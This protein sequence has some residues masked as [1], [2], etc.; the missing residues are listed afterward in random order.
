MMGKEKIK[1]G[2]KQMNKMMQYL[3]LC[4]LLLLALLW[5]YPY[6][7]VTIASVKNETDI[8]GSGLLPSKPMTLGHYKFILSTAAEIGRTPFGRAFFNS[9][10]ISSTVTVFVILIGGLAGYSLAKHEFPGR[11][12]LTNFIIFQM[13][14]PT[15]LF[16]VPVFLVIKNLHMIDTYQGMILPF[17]ASAWAVF[18]FYQFFKGIPNDLIESVRIDGGRELLIIFRIMF[19]LSKPIITIIGMF[20]FMQRWDEYLWYIV[21]NKK[22]AFMPMTNLLAGYMKSYGENLG[23]QMAGVIF[24]TFP[25]IVLFIIFRKSFTR[26]ITMTGLKG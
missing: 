26:G 21:L 6:I 19:P 10:F 23:A 7:W 18:L 25:I 8:T 17:V 5:L 20:I 22:N 2:H 13:L 14:F 1:P 9:F 15:I 12:F 3:V 16:L 4:I 11:K 24:L